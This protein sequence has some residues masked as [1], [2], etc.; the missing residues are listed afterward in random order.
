MNFH[1][2]F[3]NTERKVDEENFNKTAE[4]ED[5]HDDFN[6]RSIV[7]PGQY[8]HMVSICNP[9]KNQKSTQTKNKYNKN[10]T[11]PEWGKRQSTAAKTQIR[12]KTD[13]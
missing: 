12:L 9:N 13:R 6:G 10:R 5:L 11:K 1:N 7:A 2:I 4:T 3:L 8:P